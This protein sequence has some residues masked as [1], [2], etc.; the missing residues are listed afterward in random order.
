VAPLVA[1]DVRFADGGVGVVGC[2]LGDVDHG[3]RGEQLPGAQLGHQPQALDEVARGVHVRA[4]VLAEGPLLRVE[5]VGVEPLQRA[6]PR[7]VADVDRESGAE[8]VGQVGDLPA[9]ASATALVRDRLR[10]QQRR[11]RRNAAACQ[12]GPAAQPRHL[13]A[14]ARVAD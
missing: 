10:R 5:A 7:R 8:H 1:A 9:A 4:G 13:P 6:P 12:R 3:D 14:L 2:A 11:H